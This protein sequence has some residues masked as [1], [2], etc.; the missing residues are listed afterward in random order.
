MAAENKKA[1]WKLK[2][3][4]EAMQFTACLF[5]F[6]YGMERVCVRCN[7]SFLCPPWF[8]GH[9]LNTSIIVQLHNECRRCMKKSK[10]VVGQGTI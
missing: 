5:C 1:E 6:Y 9:S 2:T 3:Q 10:Q 7:K 8:E 4:P